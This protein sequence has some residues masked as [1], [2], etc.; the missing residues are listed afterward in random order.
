MSD[1]FRGWLVAQRNWQK[2]ATRGIIVAHAFD[3]RTKST[4]RAEPDLTRARYAVFFA[5]QP[6][7]VA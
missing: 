2:R 4:A 6:E 5:F 1:D 3:Q 7:M